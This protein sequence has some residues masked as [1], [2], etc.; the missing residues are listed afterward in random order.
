MFVE[1]PHHQIF[2]RHSLCW[3]FHWLDARYCSD[4]WFFS[5]RV[6]PSG[7]KQRLSLFLSYRYYRVWKRIL[8]PAEWKWPW[9]LIELSSFIDDLFD[10]IRFDFRLASNKIIR[11]Q[12]RKRTWL[13]ISHEI[14]TKTKE[15]GQLF[16]RTFVW[17]FVWI[18]VVAIGA[19]LTCITGVE[20]LHSLLRTAVLSIVGC[21]R[22]SW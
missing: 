8:N 13:P 18:A 22:K 5:M 14:K 12:N 10:S 19:S 2:Q 6:K 3:M 11:F 17:L 16:W 20:M 4:K 9:F 7:L 15:M 21:D 1:I